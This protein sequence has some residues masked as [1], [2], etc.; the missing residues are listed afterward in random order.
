MFRAVESREALGLVQ[1]LV[2]HRILSLVQPVTSALIDSS[3]NFVCCKAYH[4]MIPTLKGSQLHVLCITLPDLYCLKKV[5]R[6]NRTKAC[7]VV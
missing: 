6:T 5:H 3:C 4:T 2:G 7:W 1:T